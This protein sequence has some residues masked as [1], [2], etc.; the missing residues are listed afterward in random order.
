MS[1]K[2]KWKRCGEVFTII[3]NTIYMAESG[4]KQELP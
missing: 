2:R 4:K 3:W 1:D